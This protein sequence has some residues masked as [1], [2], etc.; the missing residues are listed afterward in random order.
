MSYHLKDKINSYNRQMTE[1]NEIKV[2]QYYNAK[3][4][5]P[6]KDFFTSDNHIKI[7]FCEPESFKKVINNIL[8]KIEGVRGKYDEEKYMWNLEYGTIPIENT[9]ERY[10]IELKRIIQQKKFSALLA[11]RKAFEQFHQNDY[12]YGFN[13]DY[14]PLSFATLSASSYSVSSFTNRKWSNIQILLSYDEQDNVII[15]EFNRFNGDR[16]SFYFVSNIIKETLRD[17]RFVNWCKRVEYLMFL[18]GTEYD[19]KSPILRYLSIEFMDR[20]ICEY[21]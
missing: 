8:A 1:F 15:V 12:D 14:A 6:N 13:E 2:F 7:P 19:S 18:K 16:A 20:E 11:S 21:L 17:P 10:D 3:A 9:I 4:K 5:L